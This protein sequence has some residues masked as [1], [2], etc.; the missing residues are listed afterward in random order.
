MRTVLIGGV[1]LALAVGGFMLRDR[2]P[3]LL[4][5]ADT[6]RDAPA[7]AVQIAQ[8]PA[9]TATQPAREAPAPAVRTDDAPDPL[10]D[11]PSVPPAPTA[12]AEPGPAAATP[13]AEPDA[14][15]ADLAA[16]PP[17]PEPVAAPE[18]PT[19]DAV[20]D[21]PAPPGPPPAFDVVRVATDGGTLVAGAA[22]PGSTVILRVDGAP[23][24]EAVAD[25]AGQFV[26]M[27]RLQPT[28]D[29]QTMT[30]ES[31]GSDG[32]AVAAGDTVILAP[33][34]DMAVAALAPAGPGPAAAPPEAEPAAM[35]NAAELPALAELAAPD[36]APAAPA[37][38]Q[39][40]ADAAPAGL[41]AEPALAE[42]P[43]TAP[44]EI[45]A[46]A[47]SPEAVPAPPD[48]AAP[49][50][51]T[52][53]PD[54]PEVAALDEVPAAEALDPLALRAALPSDAP[55]A[56]DAPAPVADTAPDLRPDQPAA[57]PG[58]A[59]E[60]ALAQKPPAPATAPGAA[61]QVG[62]APPRVAV[63]E[64]D[65]TSALQPVDADD[66]PGR[67]AIA[68]APMPG[69]APPARPDARAPSARVPDL[70]PPAPAPLAVAT[71]EPEP[72]AEEALPPTADA[73]VAASL[74]PVAEQAAVLPP[75]FVL[76][77]SGAVEVPG[78]PQPADAVVIDAI[79]YAETGE[80]QI[81]GRAGR[82][83]P[84]AR[85]QLYLDNEPLALAQAER[86]AW[87][88]AVPDLAP[89]L[90]TLRADQIGDDGRVATRFE[91]PFQRATPEDLKREAERRQRAGLEPSVQLVV[92]QP[93]NSLWRIS[94]AHYGE[95]IRYVQIYQ[96]NIDQIRDPDLIY[97]GQIFVLPEDAAG[98]EK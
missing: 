48:A 85:V 61:P 63:S 78:A 28:D 53:L 70:S 30:L 92:V 83:D 69:L 71:P 95:G 29:P 19:A 90:Y 18:A 55:E 27:F 23:V 86:G 41:S 49:A 79:S 97:P 46:L 32:V 10:A 31:R 62:A 20:A 98:F 68:A 75:A 50:P 6:A 22:A 72:V 16:A 37:A 9:P 2:L 77:Q 84:T 64:A 4:T 73:P 93:G 59:T 89:G 67:D 43:A 15:E 3:P 11:A 21:S 7:P 94:R 36:T 91:T 34:P 80:V 58:F 8:P 17:A 26:A 14:P 96:A 57:A 25:G 24:A 42:T 74:P 60:L 44:E 5:P 56:A 40:D 82:D 88:V 39:L 47:G 87:S 35:R 38:A 81:S 1:L 33:R 45:P 13:L 54:A 51:G 12:P 66:L 52:E 76:R 65:T